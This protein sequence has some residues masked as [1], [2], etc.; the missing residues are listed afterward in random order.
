MLN[1]LKIF[2]II[3]F[4]H[5]LIIVF[6]KPSLTPVIA[7]VKR[8]RQEQSFVQLLV[9]VLMRNFGVMELATAPMTKN[10]VLNKRNQKFLRSAKRNIQLLKSVQSQNVHLVLN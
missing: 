5:L 9:N 4:H 2:I 8:V 10:L 7:S 1:S 3:Y 6:L